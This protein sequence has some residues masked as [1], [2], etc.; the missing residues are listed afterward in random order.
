MKRE[1]AQARGL[2]DATLASLR[3][4]LERDIPRLSALLDAL[5]REAR[6]R[7]RLRAR[8]ARSA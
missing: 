5:Q 3:R 6:R 8:E 4:E 2:D 7:K 1:T